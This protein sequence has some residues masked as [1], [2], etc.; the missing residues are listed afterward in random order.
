V[1]DRWVPEE[2]NHKLGPKKQSP[3]IEAAEALDE[4][5][6]TSLLAR[7]VCDVNQVDT[8]G[9]SALHYAAQ[10]PSGLAVCGCRAAVRSSCRC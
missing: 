2:F 3:L 5:R 4:E 6:V 10:K 1:L 8:E 9:R 7:G